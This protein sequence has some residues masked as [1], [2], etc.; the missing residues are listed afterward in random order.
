MGQEHVPNRM[1]ILE[2]K[3]A[4]TSTGIEQDIVIDEH[5]GGTGSGADAA[6]AAQ[7]SY[8]HTVAASRG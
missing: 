6:T 1:Q 8:T 4:D 7:Y 3:I 5:C 2:R